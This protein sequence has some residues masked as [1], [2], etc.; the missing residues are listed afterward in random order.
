MPI[1]ALGVLAA[2]AA[3]WWF[4]S[5]SEQGAGHEP[6]DEGDHTLDRMN[7]TDDGLSRYGGA[8]S[9]KLSPHFTLSEFLTTGGRKIDLWPSDPQVENLRTVAG[10]LEKV[11][12][13]IAAANPGKAL[14]LRITSGLRNAELNEALAARYHPAARS[15]HLWGEAAD[16][17]PPPG[18][19]SIALADTIANTI[20]DFDQLIAYAPKDGGHIH[21]TYCPKRSARKERLYWVNGAVL[22]GEDGRAALLRS[23]TS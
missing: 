10:G 1:V 5:S 22:R 14:P 23:Y 6:S 17:A 18:W 11:R 9:E 13:A 16:V 8:A 19:N 12:A 20:P 4:S 21:V 7:G 2:I 3:G 15:R